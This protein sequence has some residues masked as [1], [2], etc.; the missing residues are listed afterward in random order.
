MPEETVTAPEAPAA[1][2][3]I[4]DI[5]SE[6][7]Q[8]AGTVPATAAPDAQPDLSFGQPAA[9]PEESGAP[10]ETETLADDWW[11]KLLAEQDAADPY[12]ALLS[13]DAFASALADP[14]KSQEYWQQVHDALKTTVG[15]AQ[16]LQQI[17]QAIEYAGGRG[18]L[19]GVTQ[20][21]GDLL[22]GALPIEDEENVPPGATYLGRFLDGVRRVEGTIYDDLIVAILNDPN[23]D[24][25][26][27]YN[28][29]YLLHR[30]GLDPRHY[31][32]YQTVA[33]MG[34]YT[35][36][37]DATAEQEWLQQNIPAE[38]HDTYRRLSPAKREDMRLAPLEVVVED[39]RDKQF[40]FDSQQQAETAR[41]QSEQQRAAETEW[42]ATRQLGDYQMSVFQEYQ[43][44][45]EGL[46]LSPLEAAGIAALAYID[47]QNAFWDEKSEARKVTDALYHRFKDGNPL[48]I[49][50]GQGQYKKLFDAAWRRAAAAT[51]PRRKPTAP[52]PPPQNGASGPKVPAAPPPARQPQFPPGQPPSERVATTINDI[53]REF[54]VGAG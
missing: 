2:T 27:Q 12:A 31:D 46:G 44:K 10:T 33:K 32:A 13:D 20:L 40:I 15:Q 22:R 41:A 16:T 39:L 21:A 8:P 54:G 23:A 29:D 53:M 4:G 51:P 25:Q 18:N 7:S 19:P 34:G 6:F 5:I 43:Q 9:T 47:L 50:G 52:P 35:P 37:V 49:N 24:G 3:A 42:K 14:G 38:L 26:I 17:E 45:G 48:Q 30:L 36:P 11:E 28:R 1:P